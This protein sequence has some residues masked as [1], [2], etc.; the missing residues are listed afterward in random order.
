[1]LLNGSRSSRGRAQPLDAILPTTAQPNRTGDIDFRMTLRSTTFARL[2]LIGR[3]IPRA[4]AA[5]A[6]RWQTRIQA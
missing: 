3:S 6:H 4:I 5:K 2:H 1:M